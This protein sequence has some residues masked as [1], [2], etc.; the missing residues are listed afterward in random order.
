MI[1]LITLTNNRVVASSEVNSADIGIPESQDLPTIFG[2][3]FPTVDGEIFSILD[4]REFSIFVLRLQILEYSN[5]LT[6]I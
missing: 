5:E 1:Q 2:R 6:P 4:F 3:E